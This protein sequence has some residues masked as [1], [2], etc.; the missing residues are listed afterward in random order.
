V[1]R[2]GGGLV[3]AFGE[4]CERWVRGVGEGEG[5]GEGETK[6]WVG[7]YR[8]KLDYGLAQGPYS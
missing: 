5:E 7:W 2:P 3:N 8:W 6:R 1:P 4:G